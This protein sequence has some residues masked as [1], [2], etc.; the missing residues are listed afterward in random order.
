MTQF[1]RK[2]PAAKPDEFSN[3]P[4]IIFWNGKP[5]FIHDNENYPPGVKSA[6]QINLERIQKSAN[7]CFDLIENAEQKNDIGGT[8]IA[9]DK[10]NR[11]CRSHGP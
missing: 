6:F 7:E 3:R 11:A 2:N 1:R 9:R 8:T 10:Q 5:D 4:Q